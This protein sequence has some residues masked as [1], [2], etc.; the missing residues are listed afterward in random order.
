MTATDVAVA[1]D[2]SMTEKVLDFRLGLSEGGRAKHEHLRTNFGVGLHRL[3]TK[4]SMD[5]PMKRA[6]EQLREAS[7]KGRRESAVLE[8]FVRH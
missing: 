4:R 1:A 6:Y 8:S 2:T 7:A 3:G 5:W